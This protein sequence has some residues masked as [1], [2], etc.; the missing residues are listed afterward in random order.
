[1]SNNPTNKLRGTRQIARSNS[2]WFRQFSLGTVLSTVL[3]VL[4]VAVLAPVSFAGASSGVTFQQALGDFQAKRFSQAL[5]K[6]QT[7][8]R[9]NRSDILS[10][11]YIA[12]CYQNMNQ[13]AL[14][15]PEYQWVAT[16]S[17]D[18]SL[19]SKAQAGAAQLARYQSTRNDSSP[20]SSY[21]AFDPMGASAALATGKRKSNYSS[22]RLKVIEFYTTWCKVCKTFEPEFAA[23][24][25]KYGGKCDFQ[26]LDA[27]DPA[28]KDL[29][30][31]Y[32]INS[33]PTTIFADASGK[34]MNTFAGATSAA[35]LGNFIESA[36]GQLP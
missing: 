26:R 10:H 33:F 31:K 24:Q 28:N 9:E 8:S 18:P 14:A 21:S 11:Y 6:F 5:S 34:Q 16:Y 22:G 35:G 29:A 36:M 27:E 30:M 20:S 15:L 23:A 19:R 4:L 12:L 13:V 17:K 1:M 7:I 2:I 25:A 3:L 32:K